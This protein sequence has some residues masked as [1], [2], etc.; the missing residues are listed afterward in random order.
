M[1][2]LHRHKMTQLLV[3]FK[4]IGN[5]Y[6]T[7][8]NNNVLPCCLGNKVKIPGKL[9]QICVGFFDLLKLK[10]KMVTLHSQSKSMKVFQLDNIRTEKLTLQ[11]SFL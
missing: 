10:R 2:L 7:K 1:T 11:F 9:Q 4:E 6:M 3:G 8:T 5:S